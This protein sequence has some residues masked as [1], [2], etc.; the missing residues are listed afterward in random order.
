MKNFLFGRSTAPAA[1]IPSSER[2]TRPMPLEPDDAPSVEQ[3]IAQREKVLAPSIFYRHW[4]AIR[5][6]GITASQFIEFLQ[7]LADLDGISVSFIYQ[8]EQGNERVYNH[9]TDS[10]NYE[11]PMSQA[12][13]EKKLTRERAL[14]FALNEEGRVWVESNF[15]ELK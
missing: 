7:P 11:N 4:A 14:S 6:E 2:E 9:R 5:A 10:D 3:E 13:R 15:M 8:D 12:I 1:S